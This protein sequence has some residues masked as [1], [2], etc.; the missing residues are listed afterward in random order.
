ML[1]YHDGTAW[2]AVARPEDAPAGVRLWTADELVF[3]T[4]EAGRTLVRA[5]RER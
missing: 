2:H 3:T 1:Y 5:G 4:D